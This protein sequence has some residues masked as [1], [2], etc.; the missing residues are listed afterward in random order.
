MIDGLAN[1]LKC[2]RI[3]VNLTRK[4]V[5]EI[6]DVS[7]SLIGL[8]ESGSRQPSLSAL[9]KLATLYKV[10]T[11]YILGCEKKEKNFLSLVGLTD[12]QIQAL[13]ITIQCFRNQI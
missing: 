1:R 11:D 7:E 13:N 6:I 5:S 3:N 2:S 9:V 12:K 8:Y 10:S 4:Q